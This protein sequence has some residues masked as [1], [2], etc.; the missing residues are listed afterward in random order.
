MLRRIL[1]AARKKSAGT[2]PV[3]ASAGEADRK[4]G[5]PRWSLLHEYRIGPVTYYLYR[6]EKGLPRLSVREPPPPGEE[7]LKELLTGHEPPLS[8]AEKYHLERA[9]SGYGKLYP[10]VV[11]PHIEEIAVDGPN[12]PVAVVHKA[13]PSRWIDT[14]VALSEEEADSLSLQLARKAGRIVSIASPYA[15]GLTRE[16]HRIAVTFTREISRFGS[17]A[18]LRKY[19][20]R[21]ITVAD[22]IAAGVIS[23]LAAAYLWI[24]LEAQGFL[25]IIGSMAS[26]K[27]TLLQALAGLIP[28][29][30]RVVT[31]E[32]TPEI[33]LEHPHWDSLIARPRS[34]SGEA[35]EIGL[36]ELLKFSLR[37]RAEYII[38]GEVRGR[39]ARLLAQAAA[40]GHGSLT[41][42]HADSPEGAV[43]RLRLDP[44]SLPSLFL[45]V[46]TAFVHVR[47]IPVSGGRVKRRLYSVAEVEQGE[48]IYTLEYSPSID[49]TLPRTPGELARESRKL[50]WAWEKLGMPHPSVEEELRARAEFL[51]RSAGMDPASFHEA[52]TRYYAGRGW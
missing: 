30:A 12:R 42:F 3:S 47:R 45:E 37:R 34:P 52:L 46:I 28:P 48:L 31:I 11:D 27:T 29:H 5:P 18:V 49:A 16:G 1:L 26:G 13:F 41:T 39:E 7:R 23:P 51:E 22:L 17:T 50:H 33:R 15:E 36:E 19:P 38:V 6:D 10:L 20:E 43:L 4:R 32:D 14:D 40:S 9:R 21:P 35:P 25:I 2:P 8:L 24:L 44:I